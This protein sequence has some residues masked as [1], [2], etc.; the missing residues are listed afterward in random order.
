M[1]KRRAARTSG[2]A[3]TE[4]SPRSIQH[5]DLRALVERQMRQGWSLF[6]NGSG[7]LLLVNGDLT[8]KFA[9]S[10]SDCNAHKVVARL[11]RKAENGTHQQL[12]NR[13]Q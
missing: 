10:P 3:L 6:M 12:G 1:A 5:K 7:H 9:G 13:R 11:I 2:R 8:V 4:V